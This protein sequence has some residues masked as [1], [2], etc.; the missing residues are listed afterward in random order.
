MTSK[1]G[2]AQGRSH[3]RTSRVLAA[4][5]AACTVVAGCSSSSKSAASSSSKPAYNIGVITA[6]TGLAS[7]SNHNILYAIKAGDA[8]AADEGYN[9]K[10]FVA[11]DTSTPS[12]ALAAA[13]RLVDQDH[14][15][16]VIAISDLTFGAAPYLKARGIP[17]IGGAVDSTEWTTDSNM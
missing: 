16:A 13:Q 7:A 12:G 4:A 2:A 11:D 10:Y 1:A 17:V 9:L 14:V 5:A 8:L 15:L 6:L 3:R